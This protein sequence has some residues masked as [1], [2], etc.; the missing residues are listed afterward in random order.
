MVGQRFIKILVKRDQEKLIR[1]HTRA[2]AGTTHKKGARAI[3]SGE[4]TFGST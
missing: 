2:R 1:V 4:T 3:T